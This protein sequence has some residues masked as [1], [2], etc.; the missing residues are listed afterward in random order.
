MTVK[1]QW[2]VVLGIVA[3][4]AGGAFIASRVLEDELTSITVGSDAPGFAVQ[5][6]D[7]T[8]TMKTLTDYR[9]DV[10]V[11]NIWATW[12][13]PCRTEMPSMEALYKQLGPKG[14]R[15]VAVSVDNAGEEQKIRDFVKEYDLTFEVLHDAAG[16]IQGLYRTTGVPETFV[17]DR[18]GVIRKKWIG[19]DDWNSDGNRRLL[20]Q[21]LAQPAP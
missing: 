12:C 6:L 7:P 14:L 19:A 15:I 16:T 1:Q 21:L 9:G 13:I 10:V 11:L 5:T 18:Q 8:P 4:L 20:E 17:F 3:V 2:M